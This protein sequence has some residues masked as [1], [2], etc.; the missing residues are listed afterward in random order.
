MAQK[1]DLA[2]NACQIEKALQNLASSGEACHVEVFDSSLGNLRVIVVCDAFKGVGI[3]ERQERVWRHLRENVKSEHLAAL[4]GTH[5]YDLNEFTQLFP[6]DV[7]GGISR[8]IESIRR[9][10]GN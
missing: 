8:F 1:A 9:T 2:A 7:T 6:G 3:A 5:I 10:V 4:L